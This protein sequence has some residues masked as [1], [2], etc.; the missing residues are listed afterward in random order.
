[1]MLDKDI[2]RKLWPKAPQA[3]IDGVF[4]TS[5]AVFIKYEI[6]TPLRVAHFMAQISCE[7]DMELSQKKT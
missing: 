2:L 5:G 6:N 7:S 3:L 4:A 1:M